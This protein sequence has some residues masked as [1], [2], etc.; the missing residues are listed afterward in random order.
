MMFIL[1][2]IINRVR[3]HKIIGDLLVVI[4]KKIIN[5]K[6]MILIKKIKLTILVIVTLIF[7]I[8]KK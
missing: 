6:K 4:S 5:I 8:I 7:L 2:I 3:N 1:L